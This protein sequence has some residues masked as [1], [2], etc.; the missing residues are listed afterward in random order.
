MIAERVPVPSPGSIIREELEARNWS[1]RDLAFV[2]GSPEQAI[3]MIVAGKRG[4]S[5]DMAKSM[6]D[7]FD[8]PAEFFM[9]LQRA[10]DLSLA[11]DP[12]P[13]VARRARLQEQFPLREMIKR[14]WFVDG[15]TSLLETQV[16][17]F[18]RVAS[19]DQIPRLRHAA[20]KSRY[21]VTPPAQLAWLFRVKQIAE[22]LLVAP[23]SEP[24]LRNALQTLSRSLL[25]PEEARHVPKILAECGVR[26][27]IVEALPNCNIAGVCF[28]LDNSS[29]V[30]G[31][32]M[33]RDYID[34]FWF[35]IRH[36][37][38]HVLQRHGQGEEGE[39]IDDDQTMGLEGEENI[40]A[41]ERIA[42]AAAANFLVPQHLL[43]DFIAR[44]QP[45]F[46]EQRILLFAQKLN[47]HPGLVVGQL[48]RQLNRYDF[49][50]RH[51]AKIRQ[52]IVGAAATDGWGDTYPVEL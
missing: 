51:Q 15:D 21:D 46:S 28:W 27:V 41:E 32:T 25:A 30:I 40:N 48:Q 23:Y 43:K 7:A 47:I 11:A 13:G 10:Y 5:P 44:I 20:K 1:Q 33:Q 35:V 17:R 26:F 38:E 4:I 49:L 50:K 52:F 37:I 19:P 12:D 8:V 24:A 16:T 6:G 3:N 18:F 2:L 29:P 36:E 45:Y 14:G 34:S 22:N 39:C 42:N 9:N 31:M